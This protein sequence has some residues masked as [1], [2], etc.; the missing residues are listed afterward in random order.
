MLDDLVTELRSVV[1]DRDSPDFVS[2][3]ESTLAKIAEL[4]T[5]QSIEAMLDFFDDDMY[6]DLLFSIVHMI[7]DFDEQTYVKHVVNGLPIVLTNSPEWARILF[8][9]IINEPG[10]TK[11][12]KDVAAGLA[13]PQ[14]AALRDVLESVRTS[15]PDSADKVQEILEKAQ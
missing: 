3:F 1:A 6:D 14:K 10:S 9:R 13:G 7:E 8:S 12:L 2:R 5:P 11:A 15:R 4:H